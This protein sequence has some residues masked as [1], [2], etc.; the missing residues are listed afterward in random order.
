MPKTGPIIAALSSLALLALAGCQRPTG[1][2]DTSAPSGDDTADDDL[3][4]D[5]TTA[6]PG[7]CGRL[8]TWGTFT[9]ET[10]DVDGNVQGNHYDGVNPFELTAVVVEGPCAF[11]GWDHIPYCNPPCESPDICSLAD[12]CHPFPTLVSAGTLAVTGTDPPLEIEPGVGPDYSTGAAMPY[13]YDAGAALTLTAAGSEHV[14]PFELTVLG[15]VGPMDPR[16]LTVF[17]VPGED[18]IVEWVPAEI[19]SE[20]RMEI[21]FSIDHHALIGGYSICDVPDADGQVTVPG[22]ITA[23]LFGTGAHPENGDLRRYTRTAIETNLGCAEWISEAEGFIH[24]DF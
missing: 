15:V 20:A 12:E 8:E 1:D 24:V 11:Y 3:A 17:M 19:P 21:S 9:I 13:L 23:A 16:H 18:L 2:D 5:D 7:P 22:S 14:D 6:D 4:D 10:S